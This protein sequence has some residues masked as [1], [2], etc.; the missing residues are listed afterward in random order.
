MQRFPFRIFLRATW[1]T[2]V[3]FGKGL[4]LLAVLGLIVF[5]FEHRSAVTPFYEIVAGYVVASWNAWLFVAL[6]TVLMSA[7]FAGWAMVSRA[8]TRSENGNAP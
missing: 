6:L 4:L 1:V 2:F 8:R 7:L 5:W 3:T